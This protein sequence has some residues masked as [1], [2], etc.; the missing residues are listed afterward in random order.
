MAVKSYFALLCQSDFA[1]GTDEMTV[2]RGYYSATF[3]G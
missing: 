3:N 2:T 1:Q